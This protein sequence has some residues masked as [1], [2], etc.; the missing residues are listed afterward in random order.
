MAKT[1]ILHDE[2]LNSYGFWMLTEGCD[3]SQFERNPIMFYNHHRTWRGDKAEML[4]IGHWENIRVEKKRI[5]ADA[6]FDIDDFSQTI[7][8]KVESGTL[9]M[10]SCGF[11]VITTSSDPKYMK[12]GQKYET[13]LKWKL[14]EASIVDVG[15][16]D[17]ALVLFDKSEIVELSCTSSRKFPV[18]EILLT[19]KN[20]DI[21]NIRQELKLSDSASIED[22][23]TAI[24]P[25]M[26][27]ISSLREELKSE[28]EK[29]KGLADQLAAKE[30]EE[31]EKKATK[32]KN[33]V[34]AAIKDG[35]LN[36]DK[37]HDTET[38]WLSAFERDFT[39][40]EKN[41]EALPSPKSV[42]EQLRGDES[43]IPVNA[44]EKRLAEIEE[45]SK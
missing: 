29:S 25:V 6:V 32:A 10:A 11:E 1:F 34:A 14:K 21:Q 45:N 16:N 36:D 28:K 20:M 22:A 4:P 38:F 24:Q 43:E 18:K 40:A 37:N 13:I 7:A 19:P 15:S 35:R 30:L 9:K 33:L 23:L 3:Y 31:K 17:N 39:L 42:R 2:N 12:H 5:L 27:E 26:T 8:N 41:L 44:W